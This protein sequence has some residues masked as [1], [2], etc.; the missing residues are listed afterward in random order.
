MPVLGENGSLGSPW[1]SQLSLTGEP[2]AL[3]KETVS[4]TKV[5]SA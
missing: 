2:Q 4:K 5:E 3:Q 1:A